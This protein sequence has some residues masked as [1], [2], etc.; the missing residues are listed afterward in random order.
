MDVSFHQPLGGLPDENRPR[1]SQALQTSGDVGGVADGGVIHAQVIANAADHHQ[2]GIQAQAQANL[3]VALGFE[4]LVIGVDRFLD[5]QGRHDRPESMVFEGHGGPKKSHQAV[6]QELIH[7]PLIAMDGFSHQPQGLVH[8]LVHRF[9]IQT[10]GQPRRLHDVTEED[11]HLFTL[12]LQGAAGG[13]DLFGQ[14]SGGIG[15]G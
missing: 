3:H 10:L 2:A 8:D 7:R 13:Q 6:S 12:A 11:G 15:L 4:L 1:L 9:G 5:H 14:I